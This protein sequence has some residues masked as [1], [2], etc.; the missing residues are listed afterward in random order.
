MS[1]IELTE[2]QVRTID[3]AKEPIEIR[4][5]DGR[6]FARVEVRWTAEEIADAKRRAANGVWYSSDQVQEYCKLVEDEVNRTGHCDAARAR[7]Q[8]DT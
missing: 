1:H 3:Q 2:D 8:R 5:R 7:D 6:V 4:S